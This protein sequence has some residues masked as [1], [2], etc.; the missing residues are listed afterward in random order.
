MNNNELNQFCIKLVELKQKDIYKFY[1]LKGMMNG[2]L[3]AQN[4][5]E[6][7]GDENVSINTKPNPKM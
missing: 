1:E 7:N 6:Y 5:N 3:L 2:I 4:N